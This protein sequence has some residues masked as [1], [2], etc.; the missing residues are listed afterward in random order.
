MILSLGA[1]DKVKASQEAGQAALRARSE[2]VRLTPRPGRESTSY[3]SASTPRRATRAAP[4]AVAAPPYYVR[5]LVNNSGHGPWPT[6][7]A[8]DW[9]DALN[10]ARKYMEEMDYSGGTVE[11]WTMDPELRGARERGPYR[12]ITPDHPITKSWKRG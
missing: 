4:E 9:A 7:P 1:P 8:S 6:V 11:I 10:V 2:V 12:T 5:Q 3:P